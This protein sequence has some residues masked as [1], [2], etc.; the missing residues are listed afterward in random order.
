M[1]SH[2]NLL[3]SFSAKILILFKRDKVKTLIKVDKTKVLYV[4][5][6]R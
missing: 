6:V 5:V 4:K 1:L 3:Y 2:C